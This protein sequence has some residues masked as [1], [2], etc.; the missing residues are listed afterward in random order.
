[1]L[2]DSGL[3]VVISEEGELVLLEANS[4]EHRELYKTKSLDGK[5][6]NHPVVVG[7][8]LYLRNA[9]EAVCYQL[10]DA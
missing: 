3:L 5:T 4:S 2:E 1:L 7:N 10:P 9:S 6:W 8:R